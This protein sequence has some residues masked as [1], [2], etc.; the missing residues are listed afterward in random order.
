MLSVDIE[1]EM[2]NKPSESLVSS[3]TQNKIKFEKSFFKEEAENMQLLEGT[4]AS[5]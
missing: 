3:R 2:N 5:F 1:Y 4:Y